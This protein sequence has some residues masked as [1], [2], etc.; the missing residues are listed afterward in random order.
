MHGKTTIKKN[1]Y[2]YLLIT[3]ANFCTEGSSRAT[4]F[5]MSQV[6]NIRWLHRPADFELD[7]LLRCIFVS[8][9][10]SELTLVYYFMGK[11]HP[12]C[13][14]V[15]KNPVFFSHNQLQFTRVAN[16]SSEQRWSYELC[17]RNERRSARNGLLVQVRNK[18][19]L[20]QRLHCT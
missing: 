7:N 2:S 15:I 17:K 20:Q 11:E 1:I 3:S 12:S 19:N 14:R 16:P 8:M 18:V 10:D 6:A 13:H 5:T 9:H 4:S